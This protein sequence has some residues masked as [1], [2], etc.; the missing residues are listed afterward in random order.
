MQNL[1]SIIFTLYI[2][3]GIKNFL[4]FYIHK[5]LPN[6]FLRN[7]IVCTYENNHRSCVWYKKS[8]A[9]YHHSIYKYENWKS[10]RSNCF[11]CKNINEIFL[12]FCIVIRLHQR[13]IN[14]T[15]D[16]IGTRDTYLH[17]VWELSNAQRWGIWGTSVESS[18]RF[19]LRRCIIKFN[20]YPRIG[21]RMVW[22]QGRVLESITKSTQKWNMVSFGCPCTAKIQC[23]AWGHNL[24]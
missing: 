14:W 5:K 22:M 21:S 17:L 12:P 10:H 15:D 13:M 3:N 9:Y 4:I 6:L 24:R 16:K 18:S 23:Y 7:A 1:I 11:Q 8:S 19:T 2:L 20:E